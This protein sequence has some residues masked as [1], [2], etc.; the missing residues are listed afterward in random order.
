[1][2]DYI[3]IFPAIFDFSVSLRHSISTK[4]QGVSRD[5]LWP[6]FPCLPWLPVH[7]Y[8]IAPAPMTT[9]AILYGFL[10]II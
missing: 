9:Q 6:P 4:C 1:M 5:C 10:D 2:S 7:V 8:C 3:D